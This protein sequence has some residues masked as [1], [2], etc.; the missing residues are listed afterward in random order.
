ML[1]TALVCGFVQW[2][3]TAVHAEELQEFTLDPMIVTAQRMET[4]DLDTPASVNVI[5][6]AEIKD[7]GYKNVFDAIE[8]QLGMTSTGY[9]DSGQALGW[10]KGRTVIR[11][12]DRG[13]LVLVDGIPLNLKNYNETEAVPLDFVERI[14]IVRGAAGTLYG[15]EAMGGVEEEY[16]KPEFATAVGL[17]SANQKLLTE[18]GRSK[19]VKKQSSS[20]KNNEGSMLKRLFKS[21]F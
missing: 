3:G 7:A 17:I 12:F 5:T 18:R 9:G 2:G 10:N 11:G 21:L 20:G 4:R 6:E 16:R 1:M 14:E 19:K 15:A 13:T 8:H